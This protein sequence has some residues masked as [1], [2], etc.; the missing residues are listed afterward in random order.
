MEGVVFDCDGVLADSEGVSFEAWRRALAVHGH[1]LTAEEFAPSIGTTDRDVAEA[2]APRLGTDAGRLERRA[3]EAFLDLA[4]DVELFDDALALRDRI[5]VPTAVGTNSARWRLDAILRATGVGARFPVTVTASDVERPKP[6]PDIYVAAFRALGVEPGAGMV[7]E[8]S[9]SGIA[10][11]KA[12]GATVV[13]VDRGHLPR[14]SLG[15]ADLVVG[16]LT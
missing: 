10:A 6:A 4:G 14:A 2:W 1:D 12:A 15:S 9:P 7:I 3:R 13:A 5:D 8:D 16:A 11:A